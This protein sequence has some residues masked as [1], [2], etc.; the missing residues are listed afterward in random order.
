MM[1]LSYTGGRGTL[2]DSSRETLVRR[3]IGY[4]LLVGGS[5]VILFTLPLW[6]WLTVIGAACV[7]VGWY[8]AGMK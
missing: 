2:G 1:L 6:L 4:S 3:I 8:V 7:A 5:L